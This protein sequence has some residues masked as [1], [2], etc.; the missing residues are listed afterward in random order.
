[1]KKVNHLPI[2]RAPLNIRTTLGFIK[3]SAEEHPD[4]IAM[5]VK[6]EMGWEGIDYKTLLHYIQTIATYLRRRGINKGDRIGII[7]EN[8]PE[9]GIAYL[10]IHWA[11]GI[12]VP[13]DVKMTYSEINH[14]INNAEIKIVFSSKNKFEDIKQIGE[15]EKDFIEAIPIETLSSL[16]NNIPESAPADVKEDD[17]ATL[18]YTSGTTGFSKGVVLTH[19]NLCSNVNG[20]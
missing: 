16:I 4:I 12:A 11:G 17:I 19:K 18:L 2:I 5:E 13:I 1:M 3:N 6:R 14:I 10:A 9:W 20:L 15:G 7:S 8:Q